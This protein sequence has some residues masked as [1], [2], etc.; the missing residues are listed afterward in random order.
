MIKPVTDP[1]AFSSPEG[2][3]KKMPESL[4]APGWRSNR[5][6]AKFSLPLIA[7]K[8]PICRHCKLHISCD[9]VASARMVISEK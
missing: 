2:E 7:N 5:R 9:D 3:V 8:L 1:Q 4:I 6:L